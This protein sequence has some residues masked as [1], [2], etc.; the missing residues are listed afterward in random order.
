M[1]SAKPSD[2]IILFS[3]GKQ[4]MHEPIPFSKL[5]DGVLV[6]G[7]L[8][9]CSDAFSETIKGFANNI[10]T[11]DGGTHIEG[12]RSSLTRLLNVLARRAKLLK[13]ADANL[14]GEHLREGLGAVLS[15]KVCPPACV[16]SLL[17][18]MPPACVWRVF[19]VLVVLM[20]YFY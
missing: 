5:R 12:M 9:W 19:I 18:F 2:W 4:P 17:L 10:A 15:V 11:V 20:L 14:L 16:F 1:S 7:S 8:Q 3:Q 6:E 13:E